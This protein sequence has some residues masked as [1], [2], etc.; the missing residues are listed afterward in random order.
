MDFFFKEVSHL[1]VHL[2]QKFI[3]IIFWIVTVDV[4]YIVKFTFEYWYFDF[5]FFKLG[6]LECKFQSFISFWWGLKNAFKSIIQQNLI[7][8]NKIITLTSIEIHYSMFSP[9]HF[10]PK[11]LHNIPIYYYYY[12]LRSLKTSK[13]HCVKSREKINTYQWPLIIIISR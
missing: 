10:E 6:R 11:K 3:T 9:L 2:P 7:Q 1:I 13:D 8:P 12:Y 5:D 4:P